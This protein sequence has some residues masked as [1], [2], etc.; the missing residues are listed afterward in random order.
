MKVAIQGELG[1]FHHEA[2]MRVLP[3]AEIVPQSNFAAVFQAV[4]RGDTEYGLCAIEN[5]IHGS[6]NE[7]YR[8]LQRHNVWVLH[9]VRLHIAQ[10]LIGPKA[11]AVDELAAAHDVRV[12][13]QAPA[14]A[15]VELWLDTHLPK[16]VREEIGDTALSVR[17]VVRRGDPHTLAIAGAF[18][19]ET[20][21]ATI[22]AKDIQD[23]PDNYTRFILFVKDR[24][25]APD[26][27]HASIILRTDHT[28]GALMHALQSFADHGCNLVKLDSHPIPGDQRHYAF[29]IDYTLGRHDVNDTLLAELQGRGCSVKL[30]GEYA[31]VS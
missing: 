28:P 9:D 18:A 3:D 5:N 23:E 8:L 19:A 11:V 29:Y 21:G 14:F 22:L 24:R 7:V 31:S 30:L 1:S 26:A 2:A 4:L 17:E 25:D 15:Q 13:S 27:T 12:L 6:I 10:Q 20:Y 16:A